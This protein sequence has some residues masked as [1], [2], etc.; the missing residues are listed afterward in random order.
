MLLFPFPVFIK[1]E[2][3]GS[4]AQEKAEGKKIMFENQ[5]F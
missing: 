4:S 1:P 5:R 3:T 2:M